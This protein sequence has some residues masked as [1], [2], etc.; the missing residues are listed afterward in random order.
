MNS[1]IFFFSPPMAPTRV[2]LSALIENSGLT[3]IDYFCYK[4]DFNYKMLN[5]KM[6]VLFSEVGRSRS[7]TLS[8]L[9]RRVLFTN[10]L[11]PGLLELAS[12]LQYRSLLLSFIYLLIFIIV[13]FLPLV[14][15]LSNLLLFL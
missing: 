13:Q 9:S 10:S 3:S 15:L 7:T 2:L 12:R 8:R 14:T 4:K 1:T 6:F 5:C 11:L